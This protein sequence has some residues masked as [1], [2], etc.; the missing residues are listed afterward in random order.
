MFHALHS[1]NVT[2]QQNREDAGLQ[3]HLTG[4]VQETKQDREVFEQ[5]RAQSAAGPE[6]ERLRQREA[7]LLRE[8]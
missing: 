4:L 3:E 8:A 7:E 1:E 2:Q 6:I 5:S